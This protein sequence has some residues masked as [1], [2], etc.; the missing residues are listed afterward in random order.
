MAI[1]KL[2]KKKLEKYLVAPKIH[3][4]SPVAGKHVWTQRTETRVVTDALSRASQD[5][6]MIGRGLNGLVSVLLLN[7]GQ[8]R[9]G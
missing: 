4:R 8:G 9:K 1:K 6:E 5:P 3:D 7:Y 2:V